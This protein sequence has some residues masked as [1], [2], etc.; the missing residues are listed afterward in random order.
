MYARYKVMCG[1]ECC[2]SSKIIYLQLLSWHDSYLMQLK[3][4]I[5]TPQDNISQNARNRRSIERS[6][7]LFETYKK[8]MMPHRRHIYTTEADISMTKVYAYPQFHHAFPHWKYVLR[9]F[10]NFPHIDITEQEPDR[11]H[12]NTTTSICV[13]FIT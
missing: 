8:S 2:I 10:T 4:I 6:N 12:S 9:C 13:I 3:S 5:K 7:C 1:C 11:H